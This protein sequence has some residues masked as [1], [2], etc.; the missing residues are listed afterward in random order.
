MRGRVMALFSVVFLGSTPIG[1][2]IM[3]WV[4][5]QFGPRA[6]I[7]AGGVI[8]LGAGLVT[9]WVAGHRREQPASEE[10]PVEVSVAEPGDATGLDR[11]SA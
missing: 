3:G 1:A 8:A 2:P 5:Q 9:L 7:G 6:A 10:I 11:L 4:S